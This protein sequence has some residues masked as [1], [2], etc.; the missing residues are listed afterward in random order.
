ME[1]K[2]I[3]SAL[4]IMLFICLSYIILFLASY[5]LSWLLYLGKFD[6]VIGIEASI[7]EISANHYQN[8]RFTVYQ[9]RVKYYY[10]EK[11]YEEKILSDIRDWKNDNIYVYIEKNH[12][13]RIY[14]GRFILIPLSPGSIGV[15]VALVVSLVIFYTIYKIKNTEISDYK[16]PNE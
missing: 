12:P 2:T 13:R 7:E 15:I 4:K 11:V 6:E 9:T 14:R 10:N 5:E 8:S 16:I 3:I 1:N